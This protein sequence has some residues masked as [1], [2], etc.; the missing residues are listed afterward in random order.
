MYTNG[1]EEEYKQG[2]ISSSLFGES[3]NHEE[4]EKF[5]VEPTEEEKLEI[6]KKFSQVK[7]KK[8]TIGTIEEEEKK[9]KKIEEDIKEKNKRSIFVGNISFVNE[10][11]TEKLT[12]SIQ[13]LFSK[14]GE[15]Q[16][17]RIRSIPI[18]QDIKAPRKAAVILSK[19]AETKKS[20][21]AYVVFKEEKSCKD[22]L[23]MNAKKFN[24]RHLVV[25]LA[26]PEP[27]KNSDHKKTVF[28]GNLPFDV[29]DEEVWKVFEKKRLE[30]TKVRL[31]RDVNNSVGKG[32]GYVTFKDQE[33]AKKA[34]G[35]KGI[36]RIRERILRITHS[37]RNV[38]EKKE[39]IEKNKL[40]KEE[41]EKKNP[42]EKKEKKLWTVV[43]DFKNGEIE[44]S[45][46]PITKKRKFEK[47]DEKKKFE[48]KKSF[49][50]KK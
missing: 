29:D 37:D 7:D 45:D 30:I 22:A 50:K 1:T 4:N 15:V 49:T 33:N 24:E 36:I 5:F 21:N 46:E 19:F 11:D 41:E 3:K 8:R 2:D 10:K 14:Y 23:E 44:P 26:I 31:I 39:K 17:V 42:K 32:F 12:K 34:V 25:D 6:E 38:K 48:K 47:T 28:L 43:N 20:V 35:Y 27:L 18:V 9:K 13:D 40:A 16:S